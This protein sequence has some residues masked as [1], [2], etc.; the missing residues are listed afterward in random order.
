[1][2][3]CACG[4]GRPADSCCTPILAGTPATTAE[5]LM[6]ARYTAYTR[7]DIGFIMASTHPASL[8]DSDEAAMRAWAESAE[9]QGLEIL[10]T[11][12]GMEA[13]SQGR[14][15]FVAHYALNGIAQRHHEQSLFV[16][17]DGHW[18]FR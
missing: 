12:G 1:M 7:Q 14:V 15:E 16:K 3:L 8:A 17:V 10:A 5:A 2:T 4:S 11:D 9:W 6:R 13:D 18:L